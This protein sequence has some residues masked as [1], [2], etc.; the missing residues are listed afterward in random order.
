MSD[1]EPFSKNGASIQ[2]RNLEFDLGFDHSSKEIMTDPYPL[3]HEMQSRCPVNYSNKFGGFWIVSTYELAS[4]TAS[5]YRTFSSADGAAIPR[6]P[7]T[8]LYP[9]HLDPPRQTGFRKVLNVRFSA[10]AVEKWRAPFVEE[11]HRLINEVIERGSVNLAEELCQPAPLI[12][13]L[14]LIGIPF[15]NIRELKGWVAQVIRGRIETEKA[16]EAGRRIEQYILDLVRRR[17][18]M[19]P[20]D[21][22]LGDLLNAEIMG[23]R[24]TDD[25]IFRT[26]AIVLFGGLDTTTAAMLEG[27]RHLAKHPDQVQRLKDD[28]SLWA[29]AVEEILRFTSPAQAMSRTATHDARVGDRQIQAGEKVMILFAAANRDP[30]VYEC[31]DELRID[32]F[33]NE[34][35]AF[36]RGAHVCLGRNLARIEIEEILRAI[37]ERMPDLRVAVEDSELEYHTSEARSLK[38]LPA[39]FTP[40]KRLG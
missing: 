33:P 16:A 20:Q 12:V 23:Q 24:L 30:D 26:V 2:Y 6:S 29:N 32:R 1:E 34:H 39:V 37:F 4:Q 5:N 28:V 14:P 15:E 22:V 13:V 18:T 25:D 31:P 35:L 27:V 10:E 40:S 11:V 17:R 19:P 38:E 8:P 21:D 9:I 7:N 3:Y 36:G